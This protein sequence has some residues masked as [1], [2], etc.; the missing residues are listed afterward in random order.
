MLSVLCYKST[1]TL[2]Q[3]IELDLQSQIAG[4]LFRK[5]A[6]YTSRYKDFN[7]SHRLDALHKKEVLELLLETGTVDILSATAA[8]ATLLGDKFNMALFENAW[9]VTYAY[10]NGGITYG[11]TGLPE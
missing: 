7:Y 5:K 8:V 9:L 10:I 11:G 6:E 2:Q 3:F 1:S 4:Q